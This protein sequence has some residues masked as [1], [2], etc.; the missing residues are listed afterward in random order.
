M[1][2]SVEALSKR[3]NRLVELRQPHEQTWQDCYEHSFPIRGSGLQAGTPMTA[4]QA[5]D[6][7]ARL[8]HSVATDAGRTL[9]ASIVSGATPSSSVWGS[10]TIS[11]ADDVGKTW[12]DDAAKKLH[13][14]IHAGTFDACAME[15]AL[16]LVAAG[17]FAL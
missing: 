7:K 4:N 11:G 2:A 5:Q 15:C 16:D 12:L 13:E 6:K 1:A 8:L 10:L 3:L 17:W 9:A 14:E